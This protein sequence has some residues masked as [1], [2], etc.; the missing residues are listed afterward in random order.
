MEEP[1]LEPDL[2]MTCH[3]LAWRVHSFIGFSPRFIKTIGLMYV[4]Q[5]DT[6]RGERLELMFKNRFSA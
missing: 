3:G 5:E 6:L 2:S 1:V 4:L